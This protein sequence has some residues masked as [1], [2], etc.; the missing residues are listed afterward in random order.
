MQIIIEA[1]KPGDSATMFRLLIDDKVIA[2][3]MTADSDI[4]GHLF[5][6]ESESSVRNRWRQIASGSSRRSFAPMP[7]AGA[8]PALP[9]AGS[10]KLPPRS[11]P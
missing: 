11:G 2:E 6:F 8:V 10:R 1:E 4:T 3:N 9:S 5:R 7:M